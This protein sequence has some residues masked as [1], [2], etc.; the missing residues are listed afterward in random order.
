MIDHSPLLENYNVTS[1]KP[2]SNSFSQK[3]SNL[4]EL[5]IPHLFWNALT[6]PVGR[7]LGNADM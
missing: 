5:I 3:V 6:I 4:F 2:L 7:A 1:E